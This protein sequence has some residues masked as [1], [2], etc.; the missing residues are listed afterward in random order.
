M[1]FSFC[2]VDQPNCRDRLGPLNGKTLFD[3]ANITANNQ[4]D[5]P[6]MLN[7]F[8]GWLIPAKFIYKEEEGRICFIMI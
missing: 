5:W 3:I 8:R 2:F 6:Q 1:D 7:L 4:P